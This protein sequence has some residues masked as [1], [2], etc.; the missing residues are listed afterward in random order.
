MA[1]GAKNTAIEYHSR[2]NQ[3]LDYIEKNLE[4]QFTLDELA[5]IAAFSKY[6]FHRIFMG[7]INETPFQF[8]TRLRL[9]RAA[10]MLV[11]NPQLQIGDVFVACGFSDISIFSRNF[12]QHF[13]QSPSQWRKEMIQK[14][15]L[16]Q[17]K[18]NPKKIQQELS[19]YFC[20]HT[21]SLKWMTNMELNKSIEVK[22]MP[23]MTVAYVRHIGPYKGDEEL[24]RGLWHKMMTWAGAKGLLAQ[25]NFQSLAVYHDDPN[26]TDDMKLRT[27]ICIT[28]PED[29]KVDGEIGKM[30]VE[31]GSYVVARFEVEAHEFAEAWN[32]MYASWFPKSGYQPDDKPCFELY[33]E[34]P[35]DNKFIV[36]ICVPVKP[37]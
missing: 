27:S 21:K 9:E 36:D 35:K 33:S 13:G 17:V 32:W 8:I 23:S 28:I 34:E 25:P 37:L 5:S 1:V 22:N 15:N 11:M 2:I 31:G 20:S 7:V 6:H 14:S 18:S 29:A 4:K 16:S 19:V 26:I 10:T 3:T 30:V 12:K 24:F